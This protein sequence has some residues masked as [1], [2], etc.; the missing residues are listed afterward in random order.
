MF[1]MGKIVL[2]TFL[3]YYLLQKLRGK[4]LKYTKV[5]KNVIFLNLTFSK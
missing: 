2:Q 4:P 1:S 5:M 3:I